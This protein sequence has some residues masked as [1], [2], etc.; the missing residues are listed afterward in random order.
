MASI[1]FVIRHKG[2]A[3][4]KLNNLSICKWEMGNMGKKV[5][6]RGRGLL[7]LL[8]DATCNMCRLSCVLCPVS[9]FLFLVPPN[10][11][12]WAILPKRIA[13]VSFNTKMSWLSSLVHC[14]SH[15]PH[16]LT[17]S[18]TPTKQFPWFPVCVSVKQKHC[19]HYDNSIDCLSSIYTSLMSI[20]LIELGASFGKFGK[21]LAGQI[22]EVRYPTV[23]TD[24]HQYSWNNYNSILKCSNWVL[25]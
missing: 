16:S 25:S 2:E 18:P 11:N 9:C 24:I 5:R 1:R 8:G 19:M 12:R 10:A 23:L 14:P 3:K 17:P 13:Y 7:R 4:H 22:V 21:W 20:N 15:S 6:A